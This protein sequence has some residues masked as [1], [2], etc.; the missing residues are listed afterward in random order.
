MMASTL[1]GI[2]SFYKSC[3]FFVEFMS[4][5]LGNKIPSSLFGSKFI[6]MKLHICYIFC[7][8]NIT[9]F[10]I[11]FIR[12]IFLI[13]SRTEN[14]LGIIQ[15]YRLDWKL[16]LFCLFHHSNYYR[17]TFTVIAEELWQVTKIQYILSGWW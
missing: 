1:K 17:Y 10:T 3:H 5:M 8:F 16:L 11:S 6:T 4:S 15:G 2:S 9:P 13:A 14:Q 7:M 12:F